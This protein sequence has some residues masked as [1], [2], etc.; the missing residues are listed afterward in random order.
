MTIMKEPQKQRRGSKPL[1]YKTVWL[2]VWLPLSYPYFSFLPSSFPC[3]ETQPV[4]VRSQNDEM[5]LGI[6]H[7][8]TYKKSSSQEILKSV[9]IHIVRGY[10]SCQWWK[11]W[12]RRS[13]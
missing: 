3:F 11:G 1:D 6:T 5:D 13:L 8:Q 9:V 7:K 4:T 12:S 10:T 2:Q